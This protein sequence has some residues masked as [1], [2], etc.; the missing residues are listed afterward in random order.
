M[1][2]FKNI[3]N[4]EVYDPKEVKEQTVKEIG[5]NPW[6]G[7]KRT[8]KN[9][10]SL[11]AAGKEGCFGSNWG[12][13]VAKEIRRD[14]PFHSVLLVRRFLGRQGVKHRERERERERENQKPSRSSWLS[15]VVSIAIFFRFG[16]FR[17]GF[18]RFGFLRFG[19]LR[20]GFL[21][22]IVIFPHLNN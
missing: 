6:A 10:G 17:F 9:G 7:G 18:L 14:L 3:N 20:F 1:Q 21:R 13:S 5:V 15:L 4:N 16:F 8:E 2:N 22:F 12:P 11:L 19:I